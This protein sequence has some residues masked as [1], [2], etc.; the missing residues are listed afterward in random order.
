VREPHK[1]SATYGYASPLELK[2]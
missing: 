1:G 2:R